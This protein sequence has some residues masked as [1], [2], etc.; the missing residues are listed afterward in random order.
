MFFDILSVSAIFSFDL[1]IS[2]AISVGSNISF[3]SNSETCFTLLSSFTGFCFSSGF[4]NFTISLS[5]RGIE[6]GLGF[7]VFLEVP[8]QKLTSFLL[9]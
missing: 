5:G 8:V 2:A 9:P 4:F 3:F 6:S 1:S 7:F